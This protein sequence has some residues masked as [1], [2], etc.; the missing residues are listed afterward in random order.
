MKIIYHIYLRK[1]PI[2]YKYLMTKMYS[3]T[4]SKLF[5]YSLPNLVYT[6]YTIYENAAAHFLSQIPFISVYIS[7]KMSLKFDLNPK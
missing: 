6:I 3:K 1:E 2:F 5:I 4:F 7:C